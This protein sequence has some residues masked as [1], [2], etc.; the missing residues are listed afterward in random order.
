[1][2][3]AHRRRSLGQTGFGGDWSGSL[4]FGVQF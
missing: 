4:C 2:S 1:M 3:L